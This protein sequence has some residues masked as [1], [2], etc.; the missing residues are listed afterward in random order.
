VSPEAACGG[1]IGL[2]EEGDLISIDIDERRITANLSD[3]VIAERRRN[4]KPLPPKVNTGY[5]ARYARQV[6]SAAAGAVFSEPG[7]EPGK[8]TGE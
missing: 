1:L 5:L 8:E 4:W 2:L 3:P 7:P 6:G